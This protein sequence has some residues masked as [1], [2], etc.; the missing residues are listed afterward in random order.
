MGRV[1]IPGFRQLFL[2]YR[3]VVGLYL[4]EGSSAEYPDLA[5][6]DIRAVPR[7]VQPNEY[8]GGDF[9][10]GEGQMYRRQTGRRHRRA[11]RSQIRIPFS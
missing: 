4:A 8:R 3:F 1:S 5:E 6:T 11:D 2:V 10:L 9:R 7:F